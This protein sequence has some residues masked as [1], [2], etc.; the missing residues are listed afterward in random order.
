MSRISTLFKDKKRKALIA[1]ITVGYPD[2]KATLE[3]AQLLAEAGCD[4][5]EL[6]IPFSDPMADGVT[7]QNASH[8]ALLNGVTV[9]TC[10]DAAAEIRS[11]VRIPLAFMTYLNPIVSHGIDK[12]CSSCAA[13]GI[14]GLIISDL[15]P[16]ELPE[17]DDSAVRH[18][19]DM[20]HFLAPNSSAER[21]SEVAGVAQGFIYVVSVTGVTGARDG[22][23]QDLSTFIARVRRI[24]SLPLCIGFGI[25][26][27]E[28]AVQA[29]R[30]ADGVIIGSRI[31]TLLEGS[32]PPYR[33]LAD[34]ISDVRR[35]I[36]KLPLR[37]IDW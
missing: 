3:A 25:S 28:Q 24:T 6:G 31:L 34:F 17:L 4:M 13:A 16:G 15:P 14:D 37:D 29:C 20:I 10:L 7:I 21:I 22:F 11:R 2:L 32:K 19:L 9:K 18:G 27:R 8:L 1:Y 33:A 35:G 30:L 5:I 26:S 12:F 23:A 36:D